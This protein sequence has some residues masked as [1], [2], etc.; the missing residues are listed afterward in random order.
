VTW[1][2]GLSSIYLKDGVVTGWSEID[3]KL[4]T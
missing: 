3:V 4:K 2:Y 1:G